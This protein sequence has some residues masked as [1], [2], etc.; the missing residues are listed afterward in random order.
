[1]A[2]MSAP[3]WSEKRTTSAIAATQGGGYSGTSR[4]TRRRTLSG[5]DLRSTPALASAHTGATDGALPSACRNAAF[6]FHRSSNSTALFY[7]CCAAFD[8]RRN[9]FLDLGDG[10]RFE[11]FHA[12][13]NVI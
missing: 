10:H 2:S 12:A 5:D 1:M 4:K 7:C 3:G 13:P 8:G 6:R 9:P 11:L